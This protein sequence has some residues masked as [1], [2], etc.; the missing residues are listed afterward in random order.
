MSALIKRQRPTANGT[1]SQAIERLKHQFSLSGIDNK[2]QLILG[3]LLPNITNPFRRP[4]PCLIR[5]ILDHTTKRVWYPGDKITGIIRLIVNEPIAIRSI[6]LTLS[7]TAQ[8]KTSYQSLEGQVAYGSEVGLF[9]QV[10]EINPNTA[11]PSSS[12]LAPKRYEYPFSLSLPQTCQDVIEP[13]FKEATRLFDNSLTQLLP[14]SFT[15]KRSRERCKIAYTIAATT[16]QKL[17]S[18]ASTASFDSISGIKPIAH[19]IPL[20]VHPVPEPIPLVP[21]PP[22]IKRSILTI[23][24]STAISTSPRTSKSPFKKLASTF[25]P[26]ASP[27]ES[28]HLFAHLP[29]Y[30]VA[31]QQLPITLSLLHVP[32]QRHFGTPTVILTGLTVFL[33]MKTITRTKPLT[34]TSEMLASGAVGS[35]LSSWQVKLFLGYLDQPVEM[36]VEPERMDIKKVLTEN[37]FGHCTLPK[38]I[39]D[40]FHTFNIVRNYSL[41]VEAELCCNSK[42]IRAGFTVESFMVLS[43]AGAETDDPSPDEIISGGKP[44]GSVQSQSLEFESEESTAENRK[45]YKKEELL[46]DNEGESMKMSKKS[47]DNDDGNDDLPI[48]ENLLNVPGEGAPLLQMKQPS[49]KDE[50]EGGSEDI[51]IMEAEDIAGLDDLPSSILSDGNV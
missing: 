35:L 30:G 37:G 4:A 51:D 43:G 42:K 7:G 48:K 24:S 23:Q 36:P 40:T 8:A 49:S 28:F 39:V 45:D 22:L 21:I 44:L 41:R 9:S 38:T 27:V 18:I 12:I 33:I 29:R 15:D 46:D 31:G 5:I 20:T 14:P 50:K 32:S 47:A 13:E 25:L 26:F 3:L 17:S 16:S 1:T 2:R 10:I 19:I 34:P 11:N 6:I